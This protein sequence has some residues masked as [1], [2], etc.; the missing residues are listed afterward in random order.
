MIEDFNS[1]ALV[2]DLK[3][4]QN[5]VEDELQTEMLSPSQESKH[6]RTHSDYSNTPND[7]NSAGLSTSDSRR[8]ALTKKATDIIDGGINLLSQEQTEEALREFKSAE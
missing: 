8:A 2:D 7:L 1:G 4:T 3:T 6:K 5:L